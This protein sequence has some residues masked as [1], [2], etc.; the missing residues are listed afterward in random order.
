MP[1]VSFPKMILLFLSSDH[2][3]RENTAHNPQPGLA[4]SGGNLI[5][6]INRTGQTRP[7]APCET[8]KKAMR[9][10]AERE[11]R[12]KDLGDLRATS[13]KVRGVAGREECLEGGTASH[14]L[15]RAE[16]SKQDIRARPEPSGKGKAECEGRW[17]ERL[18]HAHLLTPAHG[19]GDR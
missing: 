12:Q 13:T 19:A 8:K 9:G 4:Q 15:L 2:E 17:G 14:S 16:G 10:E 3:A 6:T 11:E 7:K 1:F 5:R 18:P